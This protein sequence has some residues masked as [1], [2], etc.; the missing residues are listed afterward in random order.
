MQQSDY[1]RLLSQLS[2]EQDVRNPPDNLR[3]ARFEAGWRDASIRNETYDNQTLRQLTWQNLGYRFGKE[4][5]EQPSEE[6][7]GAY[8]FLARLHNENKSLKSPSAQRYEE[9]FRSLNISETHRD[10]LNVHYYAPERTITATQMANAIGYPRYSAANMHYGRLGRLVGESLAFDP[11]NERLGTLV[12]FQKRGGEWHWIMRCQVARA[13]ENLGWV[14]L[15]LRTYRCLKSF[16][17]MRRFWR[18]RDAEF[19]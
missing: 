1:E 7:E 13:L 6:I 11:L 12:T 14:G 4:F 2:Y 17:K 10:M 19:T 16:P 3:L 18:A 8:R 5:D 15:G 9:A